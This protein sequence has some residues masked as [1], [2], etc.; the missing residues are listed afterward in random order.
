M[1]RQCDTW[2]FEGTAD[3]GADGR[4]VICY[5]HTLISVSFGEEFHHNLYPSLF[6]LREN[7]RVLLLWDGPRDRI[8][9]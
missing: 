9:Q 5:E 3:N 4:H 2:L 6:P 1:P 7:S 8:R